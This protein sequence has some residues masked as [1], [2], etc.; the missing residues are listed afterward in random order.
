MRTT[1]L[2]T[3]ALIG[4]VAAVIG[5]YIFIIAFTDYSFTY[6]IAVMKANGYLGK[7]ITLGAILNLIIFFILLKTN[8]EMMARGVVIATIALAIVTLFV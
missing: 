1:D 7:I 4:I 3:G 6:G 5:S 8:R 2:L